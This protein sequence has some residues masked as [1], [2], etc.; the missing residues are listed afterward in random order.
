MSHDSNNL[1]L[2]AGQT[3]VTAFDTIVGNT[4]ILRDDAGQITGR[5]TR[6]PIYIKILSS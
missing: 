1:I 2:D 6:C 4:D 5:E 3:N